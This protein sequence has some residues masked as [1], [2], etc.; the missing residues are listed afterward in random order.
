MVEI[1]I[2]IILETRRKMH[3]EKID[4]GNIYR[5]EECWREAYEK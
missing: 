3:D 5:L 1:R 4:V 2:Q